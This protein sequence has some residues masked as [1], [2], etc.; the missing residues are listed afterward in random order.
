MTPAAVDLILL[1]AGA[2]GFGI[3]G[4]VRYWGAVVHGSRERAARGARW[5]PATLTNKRD[6]LV[7]V[8]LVTK[9]GEVLRN[10]GT[11]AR[12]PK[13]DSGWL[14]EEQTRA[15]LRTDEA[16]RKMEE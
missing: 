6:W 10:D 1:A 3:L 7:M 5:E 13:S 2:A 14:L 12:V 8:V 9:S 11:I 15:Q 4:V 16:N